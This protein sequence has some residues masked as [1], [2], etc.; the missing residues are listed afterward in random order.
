MLRLFYFNLTSADKRCWINKY[1]TNTP[2]TDSEISD[3][4][5]SLFEFNQL[6]NLSKIRKHLTQE[7]SKFAVHA[8]IT[9]KLDYIAI[10][11][12]TV[13]GKC[14]WRSFNKFRTLPLES[15][16]RLVN[17]LTL[18]LFY[19]TFNGFLLVIVLFLKFLC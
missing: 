14:S 9:S 11:C 13:V 6:R 7:S 10:P 12:S 18:H 8:F 5:H 4:R 19:L 17:F 2:L 1:Y 15:L 16:L 3:N